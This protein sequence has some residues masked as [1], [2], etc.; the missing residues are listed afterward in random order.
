MNDT[1]N[2]CSNCISLNE[3]NR[4][5]RNE[6]SELYLRIDNLSNLL[7][8]EQ[9]DT[10]TQTHVCHTSISTQ[11]DEYNN[12]PATDAQTDALFN[13]FVEA[14]DSNNHNKHYSVDLDNSNVPFFVFPDQPFQLFSANDLDNST[15]YI[16]IH[17]TIDVFL[18]MGVIHTNMATLHTTPC[19]FQTTNTLLISL[20]M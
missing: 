16:H 9:N 2:C 3:E 1:S 13:I 10:F 4:L 5:L 11:S 18:I 20:L 15:T 14:S 12:D 7:F 19:P 6:I 17:Y 8:C